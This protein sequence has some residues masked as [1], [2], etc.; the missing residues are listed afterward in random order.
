M[1]LQRNDMSHFWESG[2][3]EMNV[4]FTRWQKE[5]ICIHILFLPGSDK[6]LQCCST[7]EKNWA[8]REWKLAG[9]CFYFIY[10]YF[11]RT[12]VFSSKFIEL[13]VGF[14]LTTEIKLDNQI[15]ITNRSPKQNLSTAPRLF[16]LLILYHQILWGY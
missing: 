12:I 8:R 3:R 7:W 4:K 11:F 10:I 15:S 6:P 1:Y 2:W 16:N 14:E 13:K 9:R 5:N